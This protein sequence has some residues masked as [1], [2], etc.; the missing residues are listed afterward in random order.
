MGLRSPRI[1][2]GVCLRVLSTSRAA[3]A[4]VRER[5]GGGGPCSRM[6]SGVSNPVAGSPGV[7]FRRAIPRGKCLPASSLRLLVSLAGSWASLVAFRFVCVFP[8]PRGCL[9]TSTVGRTYRSVASAS[10]HS[11]SR[12]LGG[13]SF[14]P[15]SLPLRFC[16]SGHEWRQAPP[17]RASCRL[18][19]RVR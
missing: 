11:V 7:R 16:T 18:W 3:A 1:I 6:A 13:L 17:A 2:V 10:R 4:V 5:G 9:A 12:G 19:S 15:R 8:L 14:L